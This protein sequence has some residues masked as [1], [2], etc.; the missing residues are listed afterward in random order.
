MTK[1]VKRILIICGSILIL[2]A[3]GLG[4]Y[5]WYLYHSV[6]QTAEIMYEPVTKEEY[7]S[8]DPEV[9][10]E[11]DMPAKQ[12]PFSVLVL[13]VDQR[14]NDAGR[15]DT[16]IVLAVN[17]M[18]K[19]ILMFNIPRDTR[20]EIIGH[21]R[22]DKINHAYAFGG[23][24]MSLQ[25]TEH[26]LD[27]PIDYYIKVNMEGFAQMIDLLGGVE[28]HNPFEF[29]YEGIQF[30]EG[31]LKLSGKE[32]LAYARM[33]YDDP[34]GDFGRNSRQR[35][36]LTQVMRSALQFSTITQIQSI[37]DQLGTTVKTNIKFEEMKAFLTD[38][39][40][41][42]NTIESVEMVGTGQMINGIWYYQVAQAERDR[43]HQLLKEQL[44]VQES[45]IA[46][47]GID[48]A[49]AP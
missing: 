6:K 48:A 38:Y 9:P 41:N 23:V 45:V 15:S 16:M 4:G 43:I 42:L 27:Y 1:T 47:S 25:T 26:L 35:D 44:S 21:G 22:M 17:P 14:A 11:A 3:A 37:L 39:R 8:V 36:V 33:R 13:G 40:S 32:A 20:T 18:K 34:R 30:D 46:K 24:Q 10:T 7:I 31:E 28:V 5:S 49:S 2:T 12:K 29:F 19:S